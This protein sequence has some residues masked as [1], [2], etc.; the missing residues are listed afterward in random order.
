VTLVSVFGTLVTDELT[1]SLGVPLELSSA[2]FAVLLAAV[3]VAWYR[4]EG[5]LSIHSILTRR[6]EAFYWLAILITFA[7]GTATG[8]LMAQV[9]GLGYLV[10]GIVVAAVIAAP[11]VGWRLGLHPVLAFW[12]IYVLTRPLGASIGDYLSQPTTEGGLGLGATLTS[13]VFFVGII[14]IVVYLA[15]TKADVIRGGPVADEATDRQETGRHGLLQTVVV[16]GVLLV[17]GVAGY[18]WRAQALQIEVAAVQAVP[19]AAAPA[20]PA[21]GTPTGAAH[22]AQPA[23]PTSKLGDLS[24]FRVITQDTR[25][26]LDRGVQGGATARVTDLETAWDDAQAKLKP[27]DPAAWTTLDGKIDTVLRELRSTSP[28]AASEKDALDALLAALR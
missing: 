20:D 6:R 9:L 3:F 2:V 21:P 15:V 7:L 25:D 28:D 23:A 19:A 22:A 12:I 11:A 26:L 27:R 8:D 18:F 4:V 10:S 1:D 14:A 13:L 17:T 16:V 24:R 5:T